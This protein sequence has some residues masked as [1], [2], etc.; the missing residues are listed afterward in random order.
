M[1][2]TEGFGGPVGC[3]AV[4]CQSET[5][6]DRHGCGRSSE[7][8]EISGVHI[9][10]HLARHDIKAE[11]KILPSDL[12]VANTLLSHATDCSAGLLV[13]GAYGYSRYREFLL[14]GTTRTIL[15]TMTLPIFMS[16]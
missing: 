7:Q 12:D 9:A 1:F 16:H 15:K 14:G 5:S 11:L 3:N 4:A 8:I 2:H 6:S 10:R 13:M